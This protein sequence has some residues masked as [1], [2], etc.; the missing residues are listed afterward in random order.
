VYVGRLNEVW[1]TF[2]FYKHFSLTE[3][4][5]QVLLKMQP[6]FTYFDDDQWTLVSLV[7]EC[8]IVHVAL[9]DSLPVPAFA[10]PCQC[11][12]VRLHLSADR[13]GL[14]LPVLRM[15]LCTTT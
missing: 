12:H 5:R 4:W 10:A 8:I 6:F 7:I 11:S 14:L 9:Y 13:S 2:Q 15:R 1:F 3:T